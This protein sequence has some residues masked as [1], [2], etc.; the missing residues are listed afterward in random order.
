MTCEA[1]KSR[2]KEIYARAVQDPQFRVYKIRNR[3]WFETCKGAFVMSDREIKLMNK[4]TRP[5]SF[6]LETVS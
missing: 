4:A 1:C 6:S 3:Y 5:F 2:T